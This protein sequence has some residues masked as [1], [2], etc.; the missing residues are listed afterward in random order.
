MC[1]REE[2]LERK[3]T[4]KNHLDRSYGREDINETISEGADM[5]GIRFLNSE[6]VFL[7]YCGGKCASQWGKRILGYEREKYAFG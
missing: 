7:G 3:P 2:E 5:G 6:S 1:Q 4:K